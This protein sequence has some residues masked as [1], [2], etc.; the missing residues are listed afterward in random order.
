MTPDPSRDS[1]TTTDRSMAELI[2][3]T[4]IEACETWEIWSRASLSRSPQLSV[5][6]SDVSFPMFNGIFGGVFASGDEADAAIDR[7][8][9]RGRTRQKDLMWWI[10]PTCRP[11]DL[12]ERLLQLGWMAA[13]TNT[14]MACDTDNLPD[15]PLV[16]SGLTMSQATD[17]QSLESFG[18]LCAPLFEFPEVAVGPWTELHQATAT[19]PDGR[20]S[21]WLARVDGVPVGTASLFLGTDAA[22][23]AGV[24][25]LPR[26]RRQGIAAAVTWHVLQQAVAANCRHV[27]LFASPMATGVYSR[28]GFRPYCE[29]ACLM[30]SP[31]GA[32]ETDFTK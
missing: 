16:P 25:V 12:M 6:E 5:M 31:S 20:W 18:G 29:G 23:I 26:Y 1:G 24:G 3:R 7:V 15:R 4:A 13:G 30:W 32:P 2:E 21:H 27:V 11:A 22:T 9:G 28:L 14:G 19:D 10:G 8:M 17:S